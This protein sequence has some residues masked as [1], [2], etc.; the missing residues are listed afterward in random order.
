MKMLYPEI[1]PYHTFFLA[2]NSQHLV[3]VELSGNPNGVPVIFLHGGP[4]SGTKPDHRRFFDPSCYHI[5]L[6]DQ[7]G[8]GLSEPFGELEHNTTHDLIADMERIRQQL[9]IRQWVVFGGSWGATL[10]LLYAQRHTEQVSGLI[11]RGVFLARQQDLDWFLNSG[12][13]RIFPEQWQRLAN[14]VPEDARDNLLLG[15]VTALWSEDELAQRRVTKEWS[16]WG[17]QVALG[18]DFE[19]G[20]ASEH[21]TEHLLKQVRMELHYAHHRYFIAEDQI[22]AQ[23]YHLQ[24]IPTIIIHGRLDLMCPMEAAMRL[25]AALPHATYIVLPHAG[26]IAKG[27][28]MID[29]LVSATDQMLLSINPVVD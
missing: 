26:H 20:T 13:N 11:L 21:V 9:N 1:T 4:C 27:E 18:Q 19:T 2:T 17:A 29:A 24:K 12:V 14:C 28:D 5:V 8:C 23:C 22:L 25:H 7:R 6:M 15:L 3:Y 10:A 16:A